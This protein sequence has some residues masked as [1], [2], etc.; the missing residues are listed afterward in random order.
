MGIPAAVVPVPSAEA[1]P[2]RVN[3]VRPAWLRVTSG[4]GT[5][6]GI[7]V[8][9]RERFRVIVYCSIFDGSLKLSSRSCCGV[10]FDVRPTNECS[11]CDTS[12]GIWLI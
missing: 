7:I 4:L 6:S 9:C 1:I 2:L 12:L 11:G 3:R 10:G 8:Y 5:S